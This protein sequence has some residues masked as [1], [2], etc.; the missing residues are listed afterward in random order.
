MKD[1]PEQPGAPA[2]ILF[3]DQ[4]DDDQNGSHTVY[5]RIK[6][7]NEAGRKYADVEIPYPRDYYE[8]ITEI[9]ARTIHSDGSIVEF[10]GKPLTKQ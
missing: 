4:I 3:H 7:L 1:L 10:Q 2:C 9:R 5:M 6:V 8:S